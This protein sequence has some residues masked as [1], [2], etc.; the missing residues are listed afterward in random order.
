[1][2][3]ER[4]GTSRCSPWTPHLPGSQLLRNL[5]VGYNSVTPP[6][7]D[8][9][10]ASL[11]LVLGLGTG[12]NSDHLEQKLHEF[13]FADFYVGSGSPEEL[14]ISWDTSWH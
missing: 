4:K 6:T 12:G 1:M 8:P 13:Y 14:I 5:T 10:P 11:H 3:S 9:S 2:S 7:Q